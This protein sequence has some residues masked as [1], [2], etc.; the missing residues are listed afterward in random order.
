MSNFNNPFEEHERYVTTNQGRTVT[1][2]ICDDSHENGMLQNHYNVILCHGD[3]VYTS[4]HEIIYD[5]MVGNVHMERSLKEKIYA[6]ANAIKYTSDD[7]CMKALVDTDENTIL[8]VRRIKEPDSMSK[9]T[10]YYP[11]DTVDN[12]ILGKT[13]MRLRNEI[14]I[15]SDYTTVLRDT[16]TSEY[17]MTIFDKYLRTNTVTFKNE[18]L[19]RLRDN[20]EMRNNLANTG[21]SSILHVD[22]IKTAYELVT[23]GGYSNS[24]TVNKN[25]LGEMLMDIRDGSICS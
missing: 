24:D 16:D 22:K 18:D 11:D 25:L 12:N 19:D 3:N 7:A 2:I 5:M 15:A 4:A 23:L 14:D 8:H 9:L 17:V 6:Q 20:S 13:L 21:E 1:T 10:Y